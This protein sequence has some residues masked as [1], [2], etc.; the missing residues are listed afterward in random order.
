MS[1]GAEAVWDLLTPSEQAN[2]CFHFAL[3]ADHV[4]QCLRRDG[5]RLTQAGDKLLGLIIADTSPVAHYVGEHIAFFASNMVLSA[6]LS[7]LLVLPADGRAGVTSSKLGDL[8]QVC[9]AIT[10][11]KKPADGARPDALV[12]GAG[13]VLNVDE[14]SLKRAKHYGRSVLEWALQ[15]RQLGDVSVEDLRV[16][17]QERIRIAEAR[18]VHHE[19]EALNSSLGAATFN[20]WLAARA[21]VLGMMPPMQTKQPL[22]QLR[23]VTRSGQE[24]TFL[25]QLCCGAMDPRDC[26][27]P[28]GPDFL[29]LA[30]EKKRQLNSRQ[31][32]G[33]LPSLQHPVGSFPPHE[34]NTAKNNKSYI[35]HDGYISG[36]ASS[37][38]MSTSATTTL[39]GPVF[40]FGFGV[41]PDLGLPGIHSD[42]TPSKNAVTSAELLLSKAGAEASVERKKNAQLLPDLADIIV[43]SAPLSNIGDMNDLDDI[44][45]TPLQQQQQGAAGATSVSASASAAASHFQFPAM[46]RYHHGRIEEVRLTK[47]KAMK[48]QSIAIWTCCGAECAKVNNSPLGFEVVAERVNGCQYPAPR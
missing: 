15:G 7:D 27:C 32:T 23:F 21:A 41:A 19:R 35:Y 24:R 46:A 45:G 26:R 48:V 44:D 39:G 38:G 1:C 30:E 29:A 33:F 3:K 9:L 31:S 37:S 20:E 12:V 43:S 2:L 42:N 13:S 8:F 47:T 34:S 36:A 28:T 40:Q 22:V 14:E 5:I 18:R 25:A 16:S 11:Q 4:A 6:Y 17:V 10:A